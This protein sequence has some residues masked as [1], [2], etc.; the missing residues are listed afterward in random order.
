MLIFNNI[1][2][3]QTRYRKHLGMVLDD[4]LNFGEHLKYITKKVNKPIELLRKLQ[5][6]LSLVTIYIISNYI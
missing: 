4:K 1:P 3:N 5:M 6:I 2:V